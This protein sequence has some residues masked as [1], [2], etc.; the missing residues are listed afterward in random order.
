M[1]RRVLLAGLIAISTVASNAHAS[2]LIGA[3]AGIGIPT[4]TFGDLWTSGFSGGISASYVL[5]PRFAAG[6]D[7]SYAKFGTT[8][9]YQALLD[10]ID[11]GA[12]DDFTS[13]Q[14]GVHG[15]YMI[16]VGSGSKLSPYVVA[17][18]GLYSVKDKYDSP[19]NS[20]ELS[21]TAFGIRGGLG[22]DYWISPTF[23]L[24]LDANY[25]D[26]FTNEDDIGFDNTPYFTIAA[27]VRWR[28][29]TAK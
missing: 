5:N 7:V 16:P 27:G 13:W 6:I 11:P 4:G 20:D 8:S 29:K 28:P 24:G 25:N 23:G 15:D 21:Q 12:S 10:F 18:L 19:T 2:W 26:T 17:G 3:D 22:C 9:D 1:T 14:Y